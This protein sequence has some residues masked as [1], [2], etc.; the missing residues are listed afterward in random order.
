M[1]KQT[2]KKVE[3]LKQHEHLGRKYPAG[4]ELTLPEGK[5]NWLIGIKAAKEVGAVSADAGSQADT[6]GPGA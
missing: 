1:D 5:A 4:S 3:L 2:T 6:S